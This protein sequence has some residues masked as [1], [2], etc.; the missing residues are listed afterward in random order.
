MR[1]VSKYGASERSC[2]KK[3]SAWVRSDDT[4]RLMQ[5]TQRDVN[6]RRCVIGDT[7]S[8]FVRHCT[9]VALFLNRIHAIY[10]SKKFHQYLSAPARRESAI[11]RIVVV[12]DPLTLSADLSHDSC[13][14]T[15]GF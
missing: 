15:R 1:L 2:R 6:C 10:V 4:L 12:G 3:M 14:A 8:L 13:F 11:Y 5:C 7:C 9:V